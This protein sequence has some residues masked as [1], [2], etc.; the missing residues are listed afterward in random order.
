[1]ISTTQGRLYLTALSSLERLE[2]Q[3]VPNEISPSRQANWSEI[4]IVGRNN[5][6]Y[7]YTGGTNSLSL[8]LDFHSVEEDRS[9]VVRKC[10]LL[11]SWAM[12]NSYNNPPERIKLT[13]GKLFK[14]DEIWLIQSVNPTYTQF[15]AEHNFLPVQAIVQLDL[16]LD[17]DRNRKTRDVLWN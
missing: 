16:V 4:A 15:S 11:E 9:D 2:I 7:H 13:Y 8:T 6:L 1:M 3:F 10:R 5:P 12:N 14:E 17:T